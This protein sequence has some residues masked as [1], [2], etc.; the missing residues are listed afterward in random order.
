MMINTI[1]LEELS[2]Y[3]KDIKSSLIEQ[4]L[5][6]IQNPLKRTKDFKNRILESRKELEEAINVY[7]KGNK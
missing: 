7:N 3:I 5:Y 4:R 6:W 1:T 2:S